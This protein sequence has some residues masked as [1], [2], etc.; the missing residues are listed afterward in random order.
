MAKALTNPELR[1]RLEAFNSYPD[2]TPP[3]VV[4]TA[5]R[6]AGGRTDPSPF[7]FTTLTAQR[8]GHGPDLSGYMAVGS[9]SVTLT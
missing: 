4:R 1:L 8:R 6:T 7:G 5:V 9:G 2:A 3:P